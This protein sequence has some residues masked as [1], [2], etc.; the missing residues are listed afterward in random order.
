MGG[1]FLY[2]RQKEKEEGKDDENLS[3]YE[4]WMKNEEL[5]T[6]VAGTASSSK[7]VRPDGANRGSNT[8]VDLAD[9]YGVDDDAYNARPSAAGSVASRKSRS[10]KYEMDPSTHSPMGHDDKGQL[11]ESP[12]GNDNDPYDFPTWD[13]VSE[14]HSV[15]S[16]DGAN[17]THNPMMRASVDRARR[18]S[19]FGNGMPPLP[20]PKRSKRASKS[21][22][23]DSLSLPSGVRPPSTR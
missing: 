2:K 9:I 12:Y 23:R 17:S 3:P 15:Y 20:V 22:G 16:M 19:K 10:S 6:G 7:N 21:P 8:S 5:K 1:Y 18:E 11:H 4:K 14:N 13:N